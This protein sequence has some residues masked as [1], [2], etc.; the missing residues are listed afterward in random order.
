MIN[1]FL[2]GE[3]ENENRGGE[4]ATRLGVFVAAPRAEGW[5]DL[6]NGLYLSRRHDWGGTLGRRDTW[7][8]T[9]ICKN[10]L[11]AATL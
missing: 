6:A 3:A 2:L 1:G 9:C 7:L 5:G 4:A 8:W 11:K 10:S